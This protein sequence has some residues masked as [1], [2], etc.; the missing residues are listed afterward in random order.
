MV[1]TCVSCHDDPRLQGRYAL[2]GNRLT[3]YLGSY[4]GAATQLGDTRTANCASCHGTHNILKSS[5]PL[6]ATHKDNLARTCGQCHPKAGE[7]F[8][9]G[10]VH[11]L[12]SPRQDKA[13]F[14]VR[15]AY[16]VFI[17]GLMLCF[18]SYIGLDL[19]ARVRDA[20]RGRTR[21]GTREADEPQFERLTLNQ[22]VQHWILIASF[23][24][25]I[26]TGLPLTLPGW[27]FSREVIRLLG[28]MG[29]RAV[30][31]RAAAITLTG[32]V[33]YHV[34]YVVFSRRGHW[35]FRQLLPG[36]QDLRDLMHMLGYYLGFV[37]TR[38]SF[39]RYNYIEKFEYLAMG[40]GSAVM[41]GTGILLWAP[42]I[43]LAIL[44][45]WVVDIAFVV[46]G[47][48]AIL[49]FLAI[50]VWHMYNVHWNPSVFPMSKI[51]L[52]GR[53]GLRE[54]QENHPLEYEGR[55]G[56]LSEST[57]REELPE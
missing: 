28:G 3:S 6:S 48:E 19:M 39:G 40:W 23:I 56:P 2:P 35:E 41:I 55:F 14:W 25:L 27:G 15:V 31:H 30:V 37:S 57:V 53:I 7:H 47:W 29:V 21:T 46:H 49:A 42:H 12:P 32:L 50:I 54:F 10:T 44:P 24:A 22:R 20:V 4:H 9:A 34:L 45:K 16:T 1:T 13:V 38:P 43:S 36:F 33:V 26:V 11:L 5:D 18:L 17:A 51:W 8:A 52:T